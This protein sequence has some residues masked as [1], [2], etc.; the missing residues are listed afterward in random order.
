MTSSLCCLP[1]WYTLLLSPWTGPAEL[2]SHSHFLSEDSICPRSGLNIH[3]GG[4]TVVGHVSCWATAWSNMQIEIW[5]SKYT[6]SP[7]VT[8]VVWSR[9]KRS[10]VRIHYFIEWWKNTKNTYTKTTKKQ[11][12]R[13]DNDC[14][15]RQ[16]HI[17]NNPRTT[18]QHRL[19]KYGSQSETTTNTCLWLRTRSGQTRNPT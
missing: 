11:P 13:Y 16:L 5:W 3:D 7:G 10:V 2:T 12:W 15:H 17:D 8:I 14:R 4:S 9:P 1:S 6:G 18:F 19:L